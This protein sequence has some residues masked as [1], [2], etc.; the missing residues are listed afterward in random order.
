MPA[1]APGPAPAAPLTEV[2]SGEVNAPS[3]LDTGLDSAQG[4]KTDGA[5]AQ[6]LSNANIGGRPQEFSFSTRLSNSLNPSQ[7]Q[8]LA[9]P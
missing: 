3:L 2:A 5:A 9:A 8:D 1:M 4:G 7:S 6:Q